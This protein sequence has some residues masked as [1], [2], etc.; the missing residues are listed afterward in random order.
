[1]IVPLGRDRAKPA[2]G[3]NIQG[4]W[5]PMQESFVAV[6]IGGGVIEWLTG[7]YGAGAVS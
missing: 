5:S 2:P 1:M 3:G 4:S 7:A 6:V